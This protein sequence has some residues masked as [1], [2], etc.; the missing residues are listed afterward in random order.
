MRYC[1]EGN[2]R[3]VLIPYSSIF[4]TYGK[5]FIKPVNGYCIIEPC[6]DPGL[7]KTITRLDRIGL[8]LVMLETKSNTNV[9]FGVVRYVG[10]PNREYVDEGIS[11]DGV[12][13]KVGDKVVLR[14]ISD[15]PLQY[16]LHSKIDGGKLFWRV[17]RKNI[18]AKI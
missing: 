1:F 14:R 12:D 13:V 5:D 9:S 2:D 11:D 17:Q 16:P 15:I 8:K 18:L 6:D 7:T 4:A 10:K 3:Y